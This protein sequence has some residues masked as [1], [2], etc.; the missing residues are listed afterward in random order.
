MKQ[1][2]KKPLTISAIQMPDYGKEP[3]AELLDMIDEHGWWCEDESLTIPT[4]EGEHIAN[5]RDWIIKDI[6][7]EFYLCK[8]DIFEATY[9]PTIN[10]EDENF[11]FGIALAQLKRGY[12][13]ARKGWN[14][15]GMFV[16]LVNG[17]TFIVNREP[18][19]SIMGEGTE[20]KYHAHID[21]KTADGQVVPWLASQTDMLAD[22]WC[23]VEK[24]NEPVPGNK[25]E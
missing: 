9:E 16:F 10:L 3:S 8:P 7:G 6:E 5:P 15:K 13:V 2:T 17:S 23:I 25:N 14:G 18:L 4:L 21:M 19:L 24:T 22:D 11:S 1:F 12:R 20:V